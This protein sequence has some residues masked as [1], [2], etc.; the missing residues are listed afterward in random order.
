MRHVPFAPVVCLL[1]LLAVALT[2]DR[3]I[4]AQGS[5][6]NVVG[7]WS[8]GSSEFPNTG[9]SEGP[10][11]MSLLPN[12]KLLYW[13]LPADVG[14]E[15]PAT[16]RT[17]AFLTP[18]SAVDN[19]AG[20]TY[21]FDTLEGVLFCSGHAFTPDGTLFIAGG[22]HSASPNHQHTGPQ[23]LK[24]WFY[25]Y[26]VGSYGT[27]S[28]GPELSQ[29]RWYPTVTSLPN[30]EMVVLSGQHTDGGSGGGADVQEVLT[31]ANSLRLLNSTSA[32]RLITNG[33]GVPTG[34]SW[35]EVWYPHGFVAPNGKV[36]VG[37]SAKDYQSTQLNNF[38]F[39]DPAGTGT[40]TQLGHRHSD[41]YLWYSS[42]V[43]YRPGLVLAMG[44]GLSTGTSG[45]DPG[46][47]D[48]SAI[49]K[50]IDVTAGSPAW[51]SASSL[52][53]AREFPLATVLPD[54]KVLVTGGVKSGSG[55]QRIA[56][57]EL[58][59]PDTNSWSAMASLPSG[60]GMAYHSIGLLLPDARVL[61][62]GSNFSV[63]NDVLLYK[64]P[65][66]FDGSGNPA[67]RPVIS[68]SPSTLFYGHRFQV[69]MSAAASGGADTKVSLVRLG[70]ITH[71]IDMNQRF[72]W[73]PCPGGTCSS[74]T[75]VTFD[76]PASPESMPP[77]HYMLFV[78]RGGVP[79]EAKI[80]RLMGSGRDLGTSRKPDLVF[81]RESTNDV[82]YWYMDGVT[83]QSST[84]MS[85]VMDSGYDV[86]GTNDFTNDNLTDVL[87][88]NASGYVKIYKMDATSKLAEQY[89][90]N[91]GTPW[92]IRGTG[93]FN[94][95]GTPDILWQHSSANTFYVW[96]MRVVNGWPDPTPIGGGYITS[97]GTPI[98]P[99]NATTSL[100][101]AADMNLDGQLDLVF[102]DSSTRGTSV[103]YLS[104]LAQAA[105][106]LAVTPVPDVNWKLKAVADYTGN[107]YPDFIWQRDNGSLAFWSMQDR[108]VLDSGI[109]P[110]PGSSVD[111]AWQIVGPR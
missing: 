98:T 52:T 34:G 40:W 19:L 93:D 68:V 95:D 25:K 11:H 43:M 31:H 28:S 2:G 74:T 73:L 16:Y 105:G 1:A 54:G 37:S 26:D 99:A 14:A 27:F 96:Y 94:G 4:R 88:Q 44:G 47:I 55:D 30:G 18:A 56:V 77:G 84:W 3:A 49:A 101:S 81:E 106:P 50:K 39:L 102:F 82:A 48:P 53:H 17:R 66:L 65:Y 78:L 57:P 38:G 20:S 109:L 108:T 5:G 63:N 107:G 51:S 111:T 21:T 24:T 80:I 35:W 89:L 85:P 87:V 79:S 83:V 67:T 10:I 92:R 58:W 60:K 70:S 103:V 13:G 76:A 104:G 45:V 97:S 7:A 32:K 33:S 6:P 75:T 100:V 36:F 72:D 12:G 90:V 22:G 15:N 41:G 69:T 46:T 62:G 23:M 91:G 9:T 61:Y 42:A 8:V 64:P 86:V 59:N 29:P 110:S 71:N